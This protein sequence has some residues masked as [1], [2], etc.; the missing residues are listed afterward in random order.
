MIMAINLAAVLAVKL[1]QGTIVGHLQV[2]LRF[3]GSVEME[4]LNQA[5]NATIKINLDVQSDAN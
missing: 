3:V 4:L 2:P 5:N 1:M